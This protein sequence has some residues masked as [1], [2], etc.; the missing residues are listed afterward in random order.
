MKQQ[1]RKVQKA[2]VGFVL[3]KYANIND[4]INIK[5]LPTKDE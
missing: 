1:L 4:V 5:W 3:N 2:A